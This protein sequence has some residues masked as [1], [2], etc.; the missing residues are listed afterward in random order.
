[1]YINM[2][3]DHLKRQFGCKVYKLSLS[4]GCGCPNRDREGKHG[5]IFCDGAGAFAEAGPIPEQLAAARQRV[6]RKIKGEAKYIAYF[7]SFTNTFAPVPYLEPL[8]RQAMEPEDVVALSVATRPDCLGEDILELLSACNAVKPV[9]VELGLQTVDPATA[10]LIRRGYELPV[11]DRAVKEL[12][13]RGITVIVHQIL[14]LPGETEEM[15]VNTARYIGESGADG[16]KFHMLHVLE[17][18]DLAE[19]WRQGKA[20]SLEL[21]DYI[22]ILEACLESIPREMV[23]HRLTGDGPKKDLLSPLWSGDKKRVL[24]EINRALRLDDLEQGRKVRNA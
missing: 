21:A 18:T 15:M 13:D 12:K 9:W 2:L 19:L 16:V 5:C 11:F 1:M 10:R 8:F 3:S 22:R 14:G 23:V 17:H 7:Q 24:N 6:A 20:P 4:T